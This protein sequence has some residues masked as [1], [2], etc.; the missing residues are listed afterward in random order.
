MGV[1]FSTLLL[2]MVPFL[3][4]S[5]R[6]PLFLFV[7]SGLWAGATLWS[8][9]L[10][11]Q[12]VGNP[13]PSLTTP[14]P[15]LAAKP[16][17]P[18]QLRDLAYVAN[19][20]EHQKVDLY[21]PADDGQ[22][23][24]LVVWIHGGGWQAG[25]RFPCPIARLTAQN[26]AVA[27]VGYRFSQEALFPAQ[28]EDCKAALRFLRAH[29]AEYHLDP[30]HVGV[31]GESAGGHLV[32]LLGTTGDKRQ[33][34]VG[35]NLDQSSAVQCV[36]DLFGPTDFLHY[37]P[38]AVAEF[39]SKDARNGGAKLFG[40]PIIEH[41]DAA[42][43]ASPITYVDKAAAPTLMVH[44]DK[45]PIVPLQQ[46]EIFHE[47]LTK[48]G[49]ESSLKVVPGAGHGGPAFASPE[50]LKLMGDFLDKHLRPSQP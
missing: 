24:P 10:S 27:S 20:L 14:P 8:T 6:S 41:Q 40:G 3:P 18:R 13:T 42:R 50:N 7:A 25:G 19:G 12:V 17:P 16:A 31:V 28:I 26:C 35:A 49:V 2:V 32:A 43:A 21:L 37:G 5:I 1:R 46:S 44:G 34:D 23:H 38:P 4:M 29:A 30:A 33:F 48:A 36:V 11:A 9:T 39:M 47:A 22:D 45:D 15:T